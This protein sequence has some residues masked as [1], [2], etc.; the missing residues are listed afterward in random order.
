[1]DQAALDDELLRRA[2]PRNL[3]HKDKDFELSSSAGDKPS[4]AHPRTRGRAL[5]RSGGARKAS[6]LEHYDA[7]R[8]RSARPTG[9]GR[10]GHR[11]SRPGG[12]PR[13]RTPAFGRTQRAST[14]IR[15]LR[16]MGIY[17]SESGR[18]AVK[19]PTTHSRKTRRTGARLISITRSV[20]SSQ[21]SLLRT[22]GGR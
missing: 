19:R 13:G 12:P 5:F 22:G 2:L 8:I 15:S 14:S 10:R 20:S 1:M 16:R 4:S 3:V 17:D 21:D 9:R 6:F 7:F 11:V 18:G